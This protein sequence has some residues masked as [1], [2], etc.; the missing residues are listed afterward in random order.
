MAL[1]ADSPM[2]AESPAEAA[3][4]QS[5][6]KLYKPYFLPVEVAYLIQRNASKSAP[7]RVETL[8][9]MA[10][11]LI[12]KIGGRLGFPR[13]TIATAQVLYHRFHLYFPV[14]SFAVQDMA[15]A[16]LLVSSKLEDTLKK[17]RDI[18]IAAY[19]IKAA[20]DGTN[21]F[22]EPDQQTL[23][24]DRARLI[25]IERLILET[26]SFNFNLRS[27]GSYPTREASSPSSRNQDVFAYVLKLGRYLKADKDFI[28]R[29]FRLAIDA[30]RTVLPLSY[31]PHAIAAACLYLTSYLTPE[32]DLEGLPHFD[33]GWAESVKCTQDDIEDI[34]HGILD[35]FLMTGS[36]SNSLSR[37]SP[38]E[39]LLNF[40]SP[41]DQ[42]STSNSNAAVASEL[43]QIKIRLRGET[44]KRK[45]SEQATSDHPSK[46]RRRTISN[47][48]S[49]NGSHA[50]DE[51][52]RDIYGRDDVTVRF[53]WEEETNTDGP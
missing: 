47:N 7:A 18:Q 29:A 45:S 42:A 53:L 40:K 16:T 3:V 24:G 35:L 25:G 5:T 34:C 43:T 31:P 39:S 33:E 19:Q 14:R 17:L 15:V 41:P 2:E 51:P 6:A 30:H 50:G 28:K 1:P 48:S 46:I 13:R 27:S 11:S 49:L 37:S 36:A 12:D 21:A 26:I 10:C 9:Q 38:S 44:E 8:R 4:A 32:G 23:D 52:K 20:Q 22:A